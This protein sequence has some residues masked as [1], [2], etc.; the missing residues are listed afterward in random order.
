MITHIK[1]VLL[2]IVSLLLV[3]FLVN[4]GQRGMGDNTGIA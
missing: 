3:F 2:I 1:R 4:A